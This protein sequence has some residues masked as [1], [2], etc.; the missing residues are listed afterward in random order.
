[1]TFNRRS[2]LGRVFAATVVTA[3]AW[4]AMPATAQE[5]W[6]VK[7]VRLVVPFS[8]GGSTDVVARMIGQKL[9]VLWGQPVVVENRAGAGGN[10]GADMV[11]KSPADG[12]T[13]L[14]AS[15]SI[16]INPHIYKNMSFDTRKD[17]APIT[18]VASGPMLLVVPDRAPVKSVKELIALAKES[19]GALNF[20]SAGVGSQV[21]LAGENFADAARIEIRHVPYRGESV[22]YNDLIAGQIQMMV[23]NFAAASALLGPG[24]LRA[25]AVTGKQRSAQ[26][27]DVP[28]VA[29]SG[30]PGFENT[31]WFGFLAP[32][33]TPQGIL[34][35]IQ[36]DTAKVLAE[37]DTKARLFV[38]GMTPVGNTPAEF[39]KA[40]DAESMQWATLVKNRKITTD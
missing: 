38:Q 31:G 33:G 5:R 40:M 17:L 34:S 18:N 4:G 24:R 1:M 25:L 36:I 14:M 28:T 35:K 29:E 26:L 8:P 20:G 32:A 39:S 11:A 3:A 23:G 12:Y 22:A 2:A 7:P 13:L 21:H 19:P 16:T 10:L 30:L 9:S 27:P 6:P 37:S 15:G